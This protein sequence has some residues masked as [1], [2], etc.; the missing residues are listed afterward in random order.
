MVSHHAVLPAAWNA[1][2]DTLCQSAPHLRTTLL[3]DVNRFTLTR[4]TSGDLSTA[5]TTSLLAYNGSPIEFTTSSAKPLSLSC[6]LDPFLSRYEEDRTIDAF[7]THYL[8]IAAVTSSES[9]EAAF[10]PVRHLQSRNA[11]Q[12]RFGSWLGRKYTSDGVKT[13]VYS[14]IPTIADWPTRSGYP[15]AM[16]EQAGLSLL[17]IGYYPEHF[18]ASCEYYYQ[19][20]SAVLTLSDIA[21]VMHVLG[22]ESLFPTLVPLL[23]RALQQ[24]LQPN[25]FPHTTYGFSLVYSQDQ[26]LESFTLFTMAP[27][28]FGNNSRVFPG[29]NALLMQDKQAMPLLQCVVDAKIPLQF[30]VMGFSI[31]RQGNHGISCTF[32]PQNDRFVDMP[33]QKITSSRCA[34]IPCL[35]E[36]LEQQRPSGAFL[37]HVRTPDG[38][39]HQDENAFVTAQVLR[40]LE[41]TRQTA[42]YIEKALDFLMACEIR[43]FHF[44]FWP[45]DAHPKWMANERIDADIDDTAIITELLYTFGRI[46]LSTVE[47]TL[48]QMN[49]YQVKKV[50]PRLAAVQ[51]Q[52]AECQTFHTWMKD[53]NDI[54]QLDCCVNTNVLIL[55]HVLVTERGAVIPAYTRIKQMLSKALYW[56]SNQYDRINVLTPYYA[57]PHEWLTTLYY[58]QSRGISQLTPM[59][60]VLSRWQSPSEWMESPLYRR[61]DGQFLWTSSCLNQFRYLAH[62]HRTEDTY[63]YVSH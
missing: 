48:A 34:S 35:A 40:T 59:I 1:L 9:I 38:R 36:L 33:V 27:R 43:P 15:A 24:T 8:Q 7:S 53:D 22:C 10:G 14:E 49:S 4:M 23:N 46:D 52:W 50:D 45:A 18:S 20:H 41:Y 56:S 31:D 28:F 5:F 44:T 29:V 51:H 2:V 12:L 39:W 61:H 55:L 30:N 17:M 21:S 57:H 37:A 47:Q 63:E 62:T 19:W 32:S 13:K 25:E 58:A 11:H 6:T 3:P 60:E 26:H 16:L 42:P 54:N